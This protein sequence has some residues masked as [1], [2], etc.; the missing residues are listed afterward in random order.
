MGPN[1]AIV[2]ALN[3]FATQFA[4]VMTILEKR[5]NDYEHI[6]VDTPGQIEAFTWSASGQLIA[7]SLA[8]TF[9]TN[10]VYVADIAANGPNQRPSCRTWST[11]VVYY[12][13]TVYRSQL[14]STNVTS[15]TTNPCLIGWRTSR[16]PPVALDR[17]SQDSPD[18]AGYVTSFHRSMS[19][20]LDE[21]YRVLDRVA[22]SA[23]DGSGI[24]ELFERMASSRQKYDFAP[25]EGSWSRGLRR[26]KQKGRRS[27]PGP[28]LGCSATAASA[29][30]RHVPWR[31]RRPRRRRKIA[32]PSS[33]PRDPH[34]V[35]AMSRNSMATLT[36][37]HIRS[38]AGDARRRGRHA[39]VPERRARRDAAAGG[40]ERNRARQADA[41]SD[42]VELKRAKRASPQGACFPATH[43]CAGP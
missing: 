25:M 43:R 30:F 28:S 11:L 27:P 35:A 7:E 4:D 24:D 1:G 23:V 19:L 40:A 2:T 29:R 10:V 5:K 22:V 14:R 8:S 21:F 39:H 42:V 36:E 18:G 38:Q 15:R 13:S 3:L 6:I 32:A 41:K 17:S 16:R 9:A 20:V 33:L 31:R 37:T 12:T 34:A 26:T